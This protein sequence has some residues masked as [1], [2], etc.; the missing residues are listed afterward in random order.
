[1]CCR[2]SR[3]VFLLGRSQRGGDRMSGGAEKEE[4]YKKFGYL[5]GR[6]MGNDMSGGE[7]EERSACSP[8]RCDDLH[9]NVWGHR[10]RLE[11]ANSH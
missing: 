11:R 1:M 6:I 10:E 5:S 3:A 7:K 9:S 4:D 2:L 8:L